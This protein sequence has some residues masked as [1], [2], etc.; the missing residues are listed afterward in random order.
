M[1]LLES[2]SDNMSIL[3]QVSNNYLIK[4]EEQYKVKKI[5]IYKN[6]SRQK[7]YL[8]KWKSYSDFKNI[9]KLE[10]NLNKNLKTIKKYL[11]KKYS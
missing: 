3:E 2:T 4:Q 5:L 7:Y 9:W 8:V 11:W 1:L 10:D 6:I